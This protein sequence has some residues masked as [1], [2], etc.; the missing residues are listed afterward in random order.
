MVETTYSNSIRKVSI[1][2][3]SEWGQVFAETSLIDIPPEI[4]V[5][6]R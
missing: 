1:P 6:E 2:L 3:E 4:L 5:K